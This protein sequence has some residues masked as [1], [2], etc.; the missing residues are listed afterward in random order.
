MGSICKPNWL[1]VAPGASKIAGALLTLTEEDG[2]KIVATVRSKG[3]W[4][5]AREEWVS[6][7]PTR[8]QGNQPEQVPQQL[9]Q[10][11]PTPLLSI[12]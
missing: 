9:P 2:K 12:F 7:R 6:K 3:E 5:K 8:Q 11:A 1:L 4:D 10:S